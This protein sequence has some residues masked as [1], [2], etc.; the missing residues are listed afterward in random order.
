MKCVEH[1]LDAATHLFE[2]RHGLVTALY[3]P[4]IGAYLLLSGVESQATLF[5]EIV[6]HGNLVDVG[7]GVEARTV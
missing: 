1:A 3:A 6:N 5:D 4:G 7:G 2:A